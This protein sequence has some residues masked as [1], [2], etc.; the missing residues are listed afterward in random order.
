[1]NNS[2]Y[3]IAPNARVESDT[4]IGI[5]QGHNYTSIIYLS[6]PVV[7]A[8]ALEMLSHLSNL[9]SLTYLKIM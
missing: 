3:A 1:M 4:F 5:N 8:C 2:T 6:T 9:L 7:F